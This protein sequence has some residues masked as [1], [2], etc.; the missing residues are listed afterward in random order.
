MRLSHTQ[1]V[2]TMVACAAMWSIAGVVTRL[3]ESAQSFEVTFWRSVFT[4]LSLLVIL[5]LKQGRGVFQRLLKAP[6][7]VWWSGVCWAFMFTSFMMALTLTTVAEVLITMSIGPLITALIARIFLKHQIALRTWLAIAMAGVGMAWMFSQPTA[8]DISTPWG[9]LVALLVPMSAAINW[10]LVQRAQGTHTS[11]AQQESVEL[12]PAVM[13]GALLSA[14]ATLPFAMPF[15]ATHMDVAWL[16]LLGLVQ[17]AI[18]CALVVVCARVL[19]APEISLL[20]L[21]EVL[22]GIALAWVGAGEEPSARVLGGGGLVLLG[23]L[24]NE[25]LAS[26]ESNEERI[27]NR[28]SK[29]M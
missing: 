15:Q 26:R 16:A 10:T 5:P 24:L 2:W 9:T 12:I 29:E 11:S 6:R 13:V 19:P 14:L 8:S 3:L 17:L 21:L 27:N 4:V 28:E 25:W 23:L 18:P 7:V 22:F 20:A 1:A